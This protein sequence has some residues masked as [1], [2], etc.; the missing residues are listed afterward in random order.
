MWR[1]EGC[2]IFLI[3]WNKFASLVSTFY[4]FKLWSHGFLITLMQDK[5]WLQFKRVF[6]CSSPSP[7]FACSVQSHLFTCLASSDSER[8]Q[9][10]AAHH[11]RGRRSGLEGW[12]QGML[13][14]LWL[15]WIFLTVFR[16]RSML[17]LFILP[18]LVFILFKGN[19]RELL[20]KSVTSAAELVMNIWD[21]PFPRERLFTMWVFICTFNSFSLQ[22]WAKNL[23]K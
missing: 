11:M 9:L 20:W 7:V 14:Q 8:G 4:I 17:I 6:P 15:I 5:L 21:K 1:T 10:S 22:G 16:G 18:E 3:K 23:I 12:G 19:S 13:F 2:V